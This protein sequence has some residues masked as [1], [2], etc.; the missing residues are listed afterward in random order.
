MNNDIISKKS[1]K[2]YIKFIN[3]K[4]YFVLNVKIFKSETLK[5]W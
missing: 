5:K 1:I 4:K 2:N 3:C